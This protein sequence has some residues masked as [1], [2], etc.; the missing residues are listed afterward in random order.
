MGYLLRLGVELAGEE[1][2]E[3]ARGGFLFLK[4]LQDQNLL[5]RL[6]ILSKLEGKREET[7]KE[8]IV[9]STVSDAQDSIFSIDNLSY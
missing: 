2:T 1:E 4:L 6:E 3:L 5:I 9:L 8:E 7:Y